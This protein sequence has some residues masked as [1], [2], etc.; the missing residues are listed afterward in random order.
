MRAVDPRPS[1]L[2]APRRSRVERAVPAAALLLVVLFVL[3]FSA[4]P[5][6]AMVA[7][8]LDGGLV[9]AGERYASVL[10]NSATE[11]WNSCFSGAMAAVLATGLA[12]AVSL[13]ITFGAP[14][15][16]RPL[17][18]AVLLSM[19]SP[20]FVASLAY[21]QLF[22]KRG[23]VTHGLL[24]LSVSPY[25]WQGVVVMQA[26]FFCA[27]DVLLLTA[28]LSRI[29]PALMQA[30]RGLGAR[31]G[32]VLRTVVLPVA[33]P[34]ILVCLLLT[35]IRSI[36]DYGTPVVIGGAFNTVA[37][38]IYVQL[39]GYSDL[40]A[41]AVLN[42]V[43]LAVSGLVFFAQK[44][45]DAR[46]AR[47]VEGTHGGRADAPAWRMAGPVSTA[48]Y[49]VAVTFGAF[50]VVLYLTV[51][52]SAFVRGV[53]AGAPFTL[54]NFEHLAAYDL[55]PLG[56]SLLYGILAAALA[57]VLGAVAAY[58]TARKRVAGSR[59]LSFCLSM[60]Y[61]LPG[62][63]LGLG[64]IL[65]FN[66]AW[67]VK[68]TGGALILVL[69]LATKQL[70]ISADAFSSSM[71]Q[72]SRELD[73]AARGLGAGEARM[74]RD[75]IWP[76]VRE[77]AAVSL[78]N[79]FSSAM[80]SYGALLF[81]VA[82]STKTAVVQLFDALSGGKYGNAAAVAVVL[83]AVTLVGDVLAS[84]ISSRAPR[85]GAPVP[86]GTGTEAPSADLGVAGPTTDKEAR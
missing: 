16:R 6:V 28:V 46:T 10:A 40:S 7:Q 34:A 37:T 57:T 84:R 8:S 55:A 48:L 83:M 5:L 2:P 33:G 60:P 15:L 49:V 32:R 66:G 70:A 59:V 13:C 35:F 65:A 85:P 76:N 50:I 64:F 19:A 86:A 56:R 31:L 51:V 4:L 41:V 30:A 62:T 52:R 69:V 3:C 71:A 9:A 38:Q 68:L 45:L 11:I 78:V 43:L 20:P 21:I 54:E 29:D 82:P 36:S 58:F 77:A 25:G 53:G 27:L 47:L 44:R 18:V 72:V 39:V 61:M 42:M 80:M 81:L 26:L 14:R 74:F 79:G 22:G 1:A 24:G 67:G 63:C 73:M 12:L 23:L 75:V 17:Q